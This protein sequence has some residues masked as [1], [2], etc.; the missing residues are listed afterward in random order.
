MK[1]AVFQLLASAFCLTFCTVHVSAEE[2]LVTN[3]S[4]P[5]EQYELGRKYHRG[6]G[7]AADPAKAA[8]WIRMAAESGHAEA[9][10][11]YGFLLSQGSGV[12]KNEVEAVSWMRKAAEGGVASAQ[13]NLGLMILKGAGTAKDSDEAVAWIT[14]AA[15]AG[16]VEAQARIAEFYYFGEGPLEKQPEKALPW[17]RR[18]AEAGHAWSQNL[19]ATLLEWGI[20]TVGVRKEGMMWYRKAAEQGNA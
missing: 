17:A 1:I 15:D 14:R 16:Y 4:T 9:Q 7:V 20:G 19:F 12:P 8:Q 18:G 5:R 11:Y 3:P 6:E 13:F 2:A 10:G